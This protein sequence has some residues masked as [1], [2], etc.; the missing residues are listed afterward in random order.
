MKELENKTLNPESVFSHFKGILRGGNSEPGSLEGLESL[1]SEPDL[2]NTGIRE[3]LNYTKSELDRIIRDFLGDSSEL[4]Q[5]AEQILKQSDHSLR[6]LRNEDADALDEDADKVVGGL[7]TIVRT[8]GSRPSFMIQNGEVNRATSPLGTWGDTLDASNDLLMDAIS[9]F[10][11]INL[12]WVSSRFVGTGFL[13]HENLILT[14]RH[15]LQLIG[16]ENNDG[17]W[18]ISEEATIDFGHEFR[19]LDSINRRSLKKLVFCGPD[20][21]DFDAID[22]KKLDLALI[23]LEP[24]DSSNKPGKVLAVDI[25]PDWATDDTVVYTIGYPGKPKLGVFN[26][27]LLEQLFQSTYGCKRLAPGLVAK[28][29]QSEEPWTISHDATTLGGNSGSGI[30][31]AGREHIGAGLH[32]GGRTQSPSENWGHILGKTLKTERGHGSNET[33]LDVFEKYGVVMIDRTV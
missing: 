19:G 18:D 16:K 25:S 30:L 31:V 6:V 4:H 29:L 9:C 33:L 23:E 14:N 13:I 8:D 21:I 3:R 15:V 22:H 28:S 7:E 11:R 10:G 24:A 26:Q 2:S 32:Y 12:P 20:E 27:T 5:I 1:S 17:K